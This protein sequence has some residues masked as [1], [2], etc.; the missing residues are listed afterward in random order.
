MY[1]THVHLDYDAFHDELDAVV[2]R[3][4]DAG[5]TGAMNP[6]V[7]LD[8]AARVLE[9]SRRHPHVRAAVGIHPL[10]IGR[11]EALPEQEFKA[12]ATAGGFEA[13]GEVG[14]D[15]WNGRED[16]SRQEEFFR[17]QAAQAKRLGLP[18]LL[19]VRKAFYEVV[20]A[21]DAER[22]DGAAVM[23]AWSGSWEMTAKALDRGHMISVCANITRPGKERMHAILRKVPRERLLV[24]TDAPDMPPWFKRGETHYPWELGH[25]VAALAGVLGE[26]PEEVARFTQENA[27][28]IFRTH[29]GGEAGP[30]GT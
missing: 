28:R 9:I 11:Y 27:E 1:D 23:H 6:A 25:T 4:L 26:A 7:D 20:S 29:A 15:F 12:L 22:Y 16:A 14:L 21:L 3:S 17:F 19:H 2:K 13:V 10:Y 8:S 24:E 30:A 18:L 5:V